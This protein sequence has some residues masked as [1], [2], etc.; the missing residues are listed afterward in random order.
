MAQRTIDI[1]LGTKYNGSGIAALKKGLATIGKNLVNIQAGFSMA[2]SVIEKIG[3]LLSGSFK[4]ERQTAQFKTL[5]G[6]IDEA[7]AHMA[8][9]K[10]LGDTPPFSLDQFAAASRSLMVMTDG[11]LGY[12]KSLEMIGDAAAAIGAPVENLGH[13]VGRLY[14]LIRDGQPIGR[15]ALELRNLGI[16]TP[17]VVKRLDEMQK[18]GKSSVEIWGEVENALKRYKGAMNETQETGEGLISAI[19]T[20]WDNIV[21]EFGDAFADAA[22]GG[23]SEVLDTMTKLEE[24]DAIGE[25]ADEAVEK[26]EEVKEAAKGTASVL[27]SV[28]GGVWKGIKGTVGTAWAFAA[29][30]DEA[31]RNGEGWFN[32]GKGAAVAKEYWNREVMGRKPA[33]EVALENEERSKRA[34]RRSEQRRRRESEKVIREQQEEERKISALKA[35]DEKRG[36]EKRKQDE[37]N[38]KQAEVDAAK[39]Y[40]EQMRKHEEELHK[41]RMADIR[42]EI[43]AA[44]TLASHNRTIAAAAQS[45]FD[46]AFAAYRDPDKAASQ[47]AEDRAYAAD[48]KRLHKEANSYGGKWR[49]DELSRLMAAGDTQGVSDTLESWRRLKGFSPQIEAMV[50]ASAAEKTKTTAED[51]L[52]KIETNTVDL[53]AK[54]EELIAMK[55]A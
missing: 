27:G 1:R 3:G 52:R 55:G 45:E 19:K 29:G 14:A 43:D 10:A 42:K 35:A 38:R 50:R 34:A 12:K 48:L 28:A 7:R 17:E 39:A 51:E 2:S 4:F 15:A 24:S 40:A 22:K 49:I 53:A 16:L 31:G 37:E 11:A 18:A 32:F 21:R 8:D 36:E 54:L 30:M 47:I 20:R 46:R 25:W 26:L 44:H 6:N 33:E 5:V 13:A 9:L 41:Q 23:M